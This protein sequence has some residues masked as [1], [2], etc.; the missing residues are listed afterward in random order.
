MIITIEQFVRYLCNG[1]LMKYNNKAIG[2]FQ[3]M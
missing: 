1:L 2:T 3:N